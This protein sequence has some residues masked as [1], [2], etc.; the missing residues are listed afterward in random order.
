[1]FQLSNRILYQ[2]PA[3][4]MSSTQTL[5]LSIQLRSFTQA[6][7][8]L[9]TTPVLPLS[10]RMSPSRWL[11]LATFHRS[12][13]QFRTSKESMPKCPSICWCLWTMSSFLPEFRSRTKCLFEWSSLSNRQESMS[14]RRNRLLSQPSRLLLSQLNRSFPSK[15]SKV[16]NFENSRKFRKTLI[17]LT[18]SLT[19]SIFPSHQMWLSRRFQWPSLFKC[20]WLPNRQFSSRLFRVSYLNRSLF[21][22]WDPDLII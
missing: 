7:R 1:M 13:T 6:K 18:I 9:S 17:V 10:S 8:Q 19:F 12:P 3:P 4:R 21:R 22:V 11:Q 5:L 14:S 20:L 16:S 15:W 2:R